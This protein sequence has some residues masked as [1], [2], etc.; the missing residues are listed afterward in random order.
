M[1]AT[2]PCRRIPRLELPTVWIRTPAPALELAKSTG[3][4]PPAVPTRAEAL[5]TN[6]ATALRRG[7]AQPTVRDLTL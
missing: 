2:V 5:K 3:E 7:L 6:V 1:P 4:W